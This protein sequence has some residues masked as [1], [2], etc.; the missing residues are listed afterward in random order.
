MLM[1]IRVLGI[2]LLIASVCVARPAAA[3]SD[4]YRHVFFDNSI[5]REVY[6]QSSAAKTAPSELRSVGWRLPVESKHLPHAAQR[7]PHRMAVGARRQLGCADSVRQLTRTGSRT[8][9]GTRFSSGSIRRKPSRPTI[10]RTWCC[11]M[12]AAA[13]RWQR[14]PAASPSRNRSR[15]TRAT[16]PPENGFRSAFRSRSCARRPF[17]SSAPSACKASSSTSGARTEKSTC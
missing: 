2:L 14:C 13:C 5:Q 6:F 8:L 12:R 10:C 16:F 3:Q 1:N 17:T 7:H 9:P 4:Y 11:P 15:T